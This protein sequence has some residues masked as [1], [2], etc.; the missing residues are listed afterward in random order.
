MPEGVVVGDEQVPDFTLTLTPPGATISDIAPL[1]DGRTAILGTFETINGTPVTN[2]ATINPDASV[3]T[4]FSPPS[5]FFYNLDATSGA[6][7]T[8]QAIV[9]ATARAL[10]SGA[11]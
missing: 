3:D 5:A 9:N 10:A 4:T 2:L 11:K 6:T 1:T 7:I 8:S